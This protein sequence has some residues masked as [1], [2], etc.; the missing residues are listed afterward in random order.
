[1]KI[2]LTCHGAVGLP[3]VFHP[4]RVGNLYPAASLHNNGL[5]IFGT[6]DRT[7]AH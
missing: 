1:M 6:H 3:N 4:L 5:N 2:T 7:E